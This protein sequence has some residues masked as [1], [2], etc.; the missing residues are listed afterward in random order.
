MGMDHLDAI[1]SNM[2]YN[3]TS[4]WENSKTKFTSKSSTFSYLHY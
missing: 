4:Y 3:V 1:I 2:N